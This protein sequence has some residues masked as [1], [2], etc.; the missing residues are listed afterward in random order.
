MPASS[1]WSSSASPIARCGSR[2]RFASAVGRSQSGPSRSGPR[3][4]TSVSSP[5]VGTRSSMPSRAPMQVHSEVPTTA[6]IRSL[7]SSARGDLVG[8]RHPPLAVHA[9]VAVQ[10]HSRVQPLQ[11]VL[12]AGDHLGG[13]WRR[14]GRRWP[15]TASAGR[16]RSRRARPAPGADGGRCATRCRPQA[17]LAAGL[18]EAGGAVWA[19]G[20]PGGWSRPSPVWVW[21]VRLVSPVSPVSPVSGAAAAPAAWRGTR[22][23]PARRPGGGRIPGPIRR[24]PSRP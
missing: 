17:R 8:G 16:R 11:H 9:Q 5:A 20:G 13:A 21:P 1:R 10:R 22:P 3:W 2:R 12:A 7:R 14:A 6:R 4:P 23:R 15:G 18:V 19:D 24:R